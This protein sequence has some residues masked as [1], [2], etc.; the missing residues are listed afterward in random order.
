MPPPAPDAVRRLACAIQAILESLEETEVKYLEIHDL[1]PLARWSRGRITLLGDAAHA[2]PIKTAMMAIATNSSMSVKPARPR[3]RLFRT[4]LGK[5]HTMDGGPPYDPLF[6]A[7]QRKKF[8]ALSEALRSLVDTLQTPTNRVCFLVTLAYFRATRRFFARQ[9][10][11]PEILADY[12][13]R[14]D[15]TD[16]PGAG[17]SPLPGVAAGGRLEAACGGCCSAFPSSPCSLGRRRSRR[18]GKERRW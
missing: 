12:L 2:S 11:E 13:K 5:E 15:R 4:K 17:R 6:T 3:H 10:H 1:P 18:S 8:F 14:L 7:V 16:E 9:M